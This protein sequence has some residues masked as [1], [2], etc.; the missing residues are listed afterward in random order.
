MYFL[1]S[2]FD[3]TA[4]VSLVVQHDTVTLLVIKQV[5]VCLENCT[6][7]LFFRALWSILGDGHFSYPSLC[8]SGLTS[9]IANS[10]LIRVLVVFQSVRTARRLNLAVIPLLTQLIWR[11]RET[12]TVTSRPSELIAVSELFATHHKAL[13][14]RFHACL[15]LVEVLLEWTVELHRAIRAWLRALI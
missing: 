1:P 14:W 7:H 11:Y 2:F 6:T 3:L 4:L 10:P 12:W 8:L 15:S 9:L 5:Y 13:L